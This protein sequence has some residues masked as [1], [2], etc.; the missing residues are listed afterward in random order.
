MNQRRISRI[1]K[2]MV[3]PEPTFIYMCQDITLLHQGRLYKVD[4]PCDAEDNALFIEGLT[5]LLIELETAAK[6]EELDKELHEADISKWKSAYVDNPD[7]ATASKISEERAKVNLLEF[8]V[9]KVFPYFVEGGAKTFESVRVCEARGETESGEGYTKLGSLTKKLMAKTAGVRGFKLEKAAG[10]RTEEAYGKA[11]EKTQESLLEKHVLKGRD[12]LII[13]DVVYNLILLSGS[14]RIGEAINPPTFVSIKGE[15]Y[16]PEPLFSLTD[17]KA[18]YEDVLKQFFKEEALASYPEYIEILGKKAALEAEIGRDIYKD[19]GLS[20]LERE[21]ATYVCLKV[22]EYVNEGEDDNLFRFPENQVGVKVEYDSSSNNPV[23]V[24]DK[25]A[26]D[27]IKNGRAVGKEENVLPMRHPFL[28]G[29]QPFNPI[30]LG[31]WS[32]S[33]ETA[34]E[35]IVAYLN[36]G[37]NVL[38][39]GYNRTKDGLNFNP[40]NQ[41]VDG[42]YFRPYKITKQRMAE[43]GLQQTNKIRRR[44]G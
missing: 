37:R 14:K 36:I 43:L 15:K 6:L 28:S 2:K 7:S 8:I 20:L 12:I 4:Q 32:Q 13:E 5:F 17:L 41:L 11:A 19:A 26:Y 23:V 31:G 42:N 18:K 21:G 10:E 1:R 44:S 34:E 3:F 40:Y 16:V 39:S 9:T 33:Y 27:I 25:A 24:N 29:V 22:P 38:M 35:K 30:C